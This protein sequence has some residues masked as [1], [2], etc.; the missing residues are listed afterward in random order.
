MPALAT[1]SAAAAAFSDNV[2]DAGRIATANPL[3][4]AMMRV[5]KIC[6]ATMSPAAVSAWTASTPKERARESC[7][8]FTISCGTPAAIR[9]ARAGVAAATTS[10]A[11]RDPLRPAS[12]RLRSRRS[13]LVPRRVDAVHP[14]VDAELPARHAVI[15]RQVFD[16]GFHQYV[17]AQR[18]VAGV[19]T[20]RLVEDDVGRVGVHLRLACAGHRL[21]TAEQVLHRGGSHQRSRPQGVRR[22]ALVAQLL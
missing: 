8:N 22:D 11:G 1:P 6:S 7:S 5:F 2:D 13:L 21:L 14:E 17:L 10:T 9:A 18:R 19:L 12:P 16:A 20:R 4:T 3:G 15:H